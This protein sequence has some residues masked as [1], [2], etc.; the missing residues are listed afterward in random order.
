MRKP[1]LG[2]QSK[3]GSKGWPARIL[4]STLSSAK[5][6]G[7]PRKDHFTYTQLLRRPPFVVHMGA[8]PTIN[9]ANQKPTTFCIG[10][11]L[12]DYLVK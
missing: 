10:A 4:T 5:Q 12:K 9:A 2:I 3:K 7:L 6:S 11:Q 1:A 8:A